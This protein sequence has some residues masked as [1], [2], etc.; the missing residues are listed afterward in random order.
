MAEALAAAGRAQGLEAATAEQLARATIS[1]AGALIAA[2]A[3]PAHE[4]R[5]EVTSPGGTTEAALKVLMSP[6]GLDSLMQRA[7]EAATRRG[8]D[9]GKA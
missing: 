6:D 1:G 3:R 9:L 5:K 7:V 2:D 8:R 4:L